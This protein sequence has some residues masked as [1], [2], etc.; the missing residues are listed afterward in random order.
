M[1]LFDHPLSAVLNL[2]AEFRNLL[3]F[4]T[5]QTI[6][7]ILKTFLTLFQ[8]VQTRVNTARTGLERDTVKVNTKLS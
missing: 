1:L 7:F 8:V 6:F 4:A 5:A 3:Y 2:A